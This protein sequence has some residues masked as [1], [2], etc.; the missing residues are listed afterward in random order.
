MIHFQFG[1]VAVEMLCCDDKMKDTN[2]LPSKTTDVC[3]SY[4]FVGH[5]KQTDTQFLK[6]V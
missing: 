6:D 1:P 2:T 3:S 4:P 5:Q